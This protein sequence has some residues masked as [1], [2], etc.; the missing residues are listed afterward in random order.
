M[1]EAPAV[2]AP[3][4]AATDLVRGLTAAAGLAPSAAEVELLAS[5]YPA[6]R[7]AADRLRDIAGD[8]DPAPAFDPVRLFTAGS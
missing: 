7:A 5:V 6:L 8:A 4:P 3:A 2:S 1:P